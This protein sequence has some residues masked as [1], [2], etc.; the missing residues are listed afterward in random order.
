[1]LHN[2][3]WDSEANTASETVVKVSSFSW[4]IAFS[5][6]ALIDSNDHLGRIRRCSRFSLVTV[7]VYMYQDMQNNIQASFMR[8]A[9]IP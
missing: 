8:C 6:N 3:N 9:G 4:T 7:D 1:M 2:R 5:L